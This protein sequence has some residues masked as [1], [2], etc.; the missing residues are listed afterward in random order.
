M[1]GI[2][3]R[4]VKHEIRTYPDANHV[5]QKLLP[6]NPCKAMSIKD[7][8]EKPIKV[9]FIYSVQLM[10]WVS[11]HVPINKKQGMI[12]VCIEFHDLNK[13]SPKDN[14]PTP[15]IDQIVDECAGCEVFSFM[16]SFFRV[17]PNSDQTQGINIRLLSYVLGVR[18]HIGKCLLALKMLELL[19]S[20]PCRSPY[21]TSCI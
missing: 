14:F 15:F 11:N 19:F 6:V 16:E 2:D 1:P 21:M 18:S 4:I 13:D 12:H 7:E 17:Q 5:Q 9:G 10:E 20:G 3:P 8:V